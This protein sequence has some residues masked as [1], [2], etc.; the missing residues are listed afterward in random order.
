MTASEEIHHTLTTTFHGIGPSSCMTAWWN[1]DY[2]LDWRKSNFQALGSVFPSHLRICLGIRVSDWLSE[3]V[4]CRV[5]VNQYVRWIHGLITHVLSPSLVVA[6][7]ML[8]V[9]LFMTNGRLTAISPPAFIMIFGTLASR[10][11]PRHPTK[12]DYHFVQLVRHLNIT[13]FFSLEVFNSQMLKLWHSTVV[14]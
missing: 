11:H 7:R 12:D 14:K 8:S 6:G 13:S 2:T 3:K 5:W 4:I 10:K 1:S 9:L